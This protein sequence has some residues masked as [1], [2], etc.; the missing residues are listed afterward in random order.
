MSRPNKFGVYAHED[1]ICEELALG[2][3]LEAE[4]RLAVDDG[5]GQWRWG[6]S[7]RWVYGAC[8]GRSFLPGPEDE[9]YT[10][11]AAAASVARAFVADF[12][13]ESGENMRR[14]F[15]GEIISQA[16]RIAR[17]RLRPGQTRLFA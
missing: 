16:Q 3:R 15:D 12:I 17:Q 13:A 8:T 10:T 4:I 9:G 1:C 7:V 5:D 14:S 11:Q 2:P 6:A